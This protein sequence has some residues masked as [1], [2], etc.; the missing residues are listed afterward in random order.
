VNAAPKKLN[1]PATWRATRS[2]CG[3][4]ASCGTESRGGQPGL[5]V[6]ARGATKTRVLWSWIPL[7]RKGDEMA[8]RRPLHPDVARGRLA[9]VRGVDDF[10]GV[11]RK[12]AGSNLGSI[13]GRPVIDDHDTIGLSGLPEHAF[14]SLMY[15]FPPVVRRNYRCDSASFHRHAP[16]RCEERRAGPAGHFFFTRPD[17]WLPSTSEFSD[18]SSGSCRGGGGSSQKEN[19]A[20]G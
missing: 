16:T 13:I 17:G 19:G 8:A 2:Y 11:G 7:C 10:A 20:E 3:H 5:F 6:Q 15:V 9:A 14:D 18:E 1:P 12:I 4:G